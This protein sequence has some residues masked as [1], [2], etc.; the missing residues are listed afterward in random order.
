[1]DLRYFIGLARGSID[2]GEWFTGI[3]DGEREVIPIVCM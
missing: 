3:A 1:M 2:A